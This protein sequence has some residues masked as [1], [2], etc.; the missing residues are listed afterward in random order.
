M[1]KRHY[2]PLIQDDIE[3]NECGESVP[4]DNTIACSG[5]G[6]AVCFNC[7][8]DDLCDTCAERD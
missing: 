5:C 2:N 8:V 6:F 7:A 1:A 4:E 3:C